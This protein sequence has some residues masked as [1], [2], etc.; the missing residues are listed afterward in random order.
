[1]LRYHANR[2]SRIYALCT[3]VAVSMVASSVGAATIL[4]ENFDGST[5]LP[6][7][8]TKQNNVAVV[9][10][11]AYAASG[12]NTLWIVETRNSNVV[13]APTL[14]LTGATEATLSF[15]WTTDA[16]QSSKFGRIPQIQYSSDGVNFNTIGSFTV[17]SST[18]TIPPHTLF[19][20][21]ITTL[22]GY[23]FTSNS[24]FRIVGDNDGGGSGAPLIID[25]FTVTS[26]VPEPGSL[27]L[28]AIGGMLIV[29]R[30]RNG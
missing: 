5:A 4:F 6:T 22:G 14:D 19:S 11:A 17:P 26:D 12:T 16:P 15:L 20:A 9:D 23:A 18:T 24:V 13:T 1:M 7:G 8:W 30:R 10:D 21:T 27:A 29:N 28:L 25:D 3:V 2:P